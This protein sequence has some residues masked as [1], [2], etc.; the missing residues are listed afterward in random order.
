MQAGAKEV[1]WIPLDV[2]LRQA[3]Q[4]QDCQNI[5][6]YIAEENGEYDTARRYADLTQQHINACA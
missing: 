2:P 1:V 4:M 6:Y 5:E 3:R